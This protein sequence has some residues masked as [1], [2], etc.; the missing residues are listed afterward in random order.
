MSSP[1]L[2]FENWPPPL[3]RLEQRQAYPHN[4][5]YLK[6]KHLQISYNEVRFKQVFQRPC[7]WLPKVSIFEKVCS[8]ALPTLLRIRLAVW[9]RT[10][11][12][13]SITPETLRNFPSRQYPRNHNA[14]KSNRSDL[15]REKPTRHSQDGQKRR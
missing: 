12:V 15:K 4:L 13:I 1:L 14:I 2:N 3:Q 5:E 9:L 8:R 7:A 11:S 6:E 10:K